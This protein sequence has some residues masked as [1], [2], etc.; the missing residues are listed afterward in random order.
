MSSR[1]KRPRKAQSPSSGITTLFI[2]VG[3]GGLLLLAWPL[4]SLK[5]I[6]ELAGRQTLLATLPDVATAAPGDLAI[7]DGRV[8][9]SV[10]QLHN[11]FVAYVRERRQS[12]K[13]ASSAW[14]YVDG[15]QQPLVVEAGTRAYTFDDDG[16][17]FDRLLWNWTDAERWDE[18][19]TT[20]RGAIRIQGIVADGP[21]MAVG[22]L[23]PDDGGGLVFDA[24]SVVG[25]S[26]AEYAQRLDA[27]YAYEWKFAGIVFL[28]AL[29]GMAVG[30]I[31]VRRYQQE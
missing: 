24:D 9:A 5:T 11:D 31:G 30:W 7:L 2:L 12:G 27:R 20:L 6:Y 10:P 13:Y 17:R 15:A 28:M 26:R 18:E 1:P 3:I 21:V 25:L 16:Y 22:R 8:G 19:A 4:M 14:Q 29:I 23:R